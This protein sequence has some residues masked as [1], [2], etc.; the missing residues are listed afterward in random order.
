MVIV[1]AKDIEDYEASTHRFFFADKNV[2]KLRTSILVSI[3]KTTLE[4]PI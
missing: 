1:M 4:V 2:R 3:E